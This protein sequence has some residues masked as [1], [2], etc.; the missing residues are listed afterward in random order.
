M[1]ED[2]DI[3]T[4]GGSFIGGDVKSEGDV[5]GRDQIIQN[6]LIVG[7]FLDFAKVSEL[8]PQPG[9]TADF[10]EISEAFKKAFGD[11]AGRDL[12]YAT[13]FAGELLR[14]LVLELKP[15]N[16]FAAF[17]YGSMLEEIGPEI[18][19]KL[20]DLGHWDIVSKPLEDELA[21]HLRFT[22]YSNPKILW[23]PS[24]E[25]LWENKYSEEFRFGFIEGKEYK[26]TE[27]SKVMVVF[28]GHITGRMENYQWSHDFLQTIFAGIVVDL[29]RIGSLN[30]SDK[31]FWERLVNFLGSDSS[32]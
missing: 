9:K 14:D 26:S 20:Q 7:Q 6:I 3:N 24:L 12:A 22:L 2:R 32:E 29:V 16:P 1:S 15:E 23:L 19:K 27:R 30:S 8:L 28:G 11:E 21:K 25:Q 5:I 17:P 18:I 4:A 31:Q 13:S 10:K